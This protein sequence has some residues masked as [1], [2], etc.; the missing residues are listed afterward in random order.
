VPAGTPPS[1]WLEALLRADFGPM[2]DTFDFSEDDRRYDEE[3]NDPVALG[4][5]WSGARRSGVT[6]DV[7][8]IAAPSLII[9]GGASDPESSKEVAAA[10]G[11]PLH[12]LPGLDH[13]QAFSRIDLVMPLVLAFLEPL[14]L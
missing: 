12:V 10:L 4:A 6:I 5:L 9:A 14:G 1:P 8:R 2:W 13:L 3:V 11:V 7:G